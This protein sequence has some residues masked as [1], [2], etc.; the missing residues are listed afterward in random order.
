MGV[1]TSG[2]FN[3]F[4]SGDNTTIQGAIEEGGGTTTGITDFNGLISVS[5]INKF[6]PAFSEGATSLG[7]ITKTTQFRGYPIATATPTP[8]PTPTLTPTPTPTATPTPTP[9]PT[10]AGIEIASVD[11][12][13]GESCGGNSSQSFT[14][15]VWI[16]TSQLP[17]NT[18]TGKINN[19]TSI[20]T[21]PLTVYQP[22][23]PGT[24][25]ASWSIIQ[26]GTANVSQG[27]YLVQDISL[28]NTSNDVEA[29]VNLSGDI[30][31]QTCGL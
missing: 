23:D 5:D 21:F 22:G 1:P 26:S 16:D 13:S 2:N 25:V 31:F 18:S 15:R 27:T 4:G 7:D 10:P 14:N 11:L 17:F 3:M 29:T 19:G 9:T 28:S 12:V 8:T 6:D 20:T 30:T 24:T